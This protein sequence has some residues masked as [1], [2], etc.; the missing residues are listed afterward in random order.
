MID[1]AG[2][3]WGKNAVTASI[4]SMY[5]PCIPLVKGIIVAVP[6]P[7]RHPRPPTPAP[8]TVADVTAPTPMTVHFA[9]TAILAGAT[10]AFSKRG[11]GVTRVE[12]IL[13][14]AK[15]ARRTFYRYF[16]SKEEVLAALFD[17]WT[18]EIVKSIEGARARHPDSPFAGIRAGIDIYLGFYRSGPRVVRELVEIAMQSDSLLAPRRKRLRAHIVRLLD[19]AVYAL[20]GRRLDPFVYLGLLSLLEGISIE[21]G[22]PDPT[23]DDVERARLVVHAIVDQT[24]GL[25]QPAALPMKPARGRGDT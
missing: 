13:I 7:R 18:G 1:A 20:D 15:I 19:E 6:V 9:R 16:A 25:P 22:D 12:D 17:V 23:P 24:L 21:L 4:P 5:T 10:K 8:G 3:G 11:I 2:S 14:A